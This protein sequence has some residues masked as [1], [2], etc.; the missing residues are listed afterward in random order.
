[1]KY[2]VEMDPGATV[3]IQSFIKI[4]LGIEMGDTQIHTLNNYGKPIP[5]LLFF[6][7]VKEAKK[8]LVLN[9]ER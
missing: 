2:A 3:Y 4:A 1:M 8:K 6:H 7:N 5:L 9:Q